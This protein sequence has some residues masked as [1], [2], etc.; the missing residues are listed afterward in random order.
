MGRAVRER[1]KLCVILRFLAQAVGET[2]GS[3][4]A[5]T[6]EEQIRGSI[7]PKV[8]LGSLGRESS[9]DSCGLVLMCKPERL[10]F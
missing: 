7:L 1:R 3:T 5:P 8:P 10:C 6:W 9:V 2:Y 4:I